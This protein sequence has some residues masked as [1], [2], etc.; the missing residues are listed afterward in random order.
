MLRPRLGASAKFGHDNERVGIVFEAWSLKHRSEHVVGE[1]RQAVCSV[2]QTRT[3][4]KLL[5]VLVLCKLLVTLI[6]SS[7][8]APFILDILLHLRVSGNPRVLLGLM[9]LA[10]L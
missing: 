7:L 3:S 9:K 1:D 4:T 10:G 6:S 5:K 8:D 2:L